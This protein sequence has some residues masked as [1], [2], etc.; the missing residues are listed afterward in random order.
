MVAGDKI[1]TVYAQ[2][3]VELAREGS[4]LEGIAEEMDSVVG[5]LTSDPK[6]WK[7]FKS[8]IVSGDNKLNILKKT[9]QPHVRPMIF[10]FLGVLAAR[11][12]FEHLPEI[13]ESFRLL[14]DRELGRRRFYITTAVTMEGALQTELT[15]ALTAAFKAQAIL[16]LKVDPEL[17]GGVVV[18]S[19]DIMIDTSIKNNLEHIRRNMI[20]CN[21]SG[22]GFYEN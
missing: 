10:H 6:I 20:K 8:P 11:M 16:E 1:A 22:E 17:I 21:I 5:A 18:E 7:F 9:I 14:L 2:S 15:K 12:R 3:L 13:N 19:E 4:A